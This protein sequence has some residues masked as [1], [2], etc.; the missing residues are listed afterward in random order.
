MTKKTRHDD[1]RISEENIDEDRVLPTYS[2]TMTVHDDIN[3]ETDNNLAEAGCNL[4]ADWRERMSTDHAISWL[5][6]IG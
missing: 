2:G 5:Q 3:T 6:I 1:T 4:L